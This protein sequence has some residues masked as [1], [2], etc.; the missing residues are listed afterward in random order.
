MLIGLS[1]QAWEYYESAQALLPLI[2][3]DSRGA[4]WVLVEI[5]SGL[6]KK[7]DEREGDV[8]SMRVSVPTRQKILALARGAAM[9]LGA[10]KS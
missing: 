5:Y 2:D 6:L 8:F 7:I 1:V 4:L 9:S 3:A 10:R